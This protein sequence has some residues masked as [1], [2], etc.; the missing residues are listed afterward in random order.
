MNDC[1]CTRMCPICKARVGRHSKVS[2]WGIIIFFGLMVLILML[3]SCVRT[4]EQHNEIGKKKLA[5]LRKFYPDLFTK[6]VDTT[7]NRDSLVTETEWPDQAQIDSLLDE[8]CR[9]NSKPDTTKTGKD[10]IIYRDRTIAKYLKKEVFNPQKIYGVY[11]KITTK[12]AVIH[13]WYSPDGRRDWVVE[14]ETIRNTEECP[15]CPETEKGWRIQAGIVF[16]LLLIAFI[17]GLFFKTIVKLF[18]PLR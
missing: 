9:R 10:T 11:E 15:A 18:N 12:N 3:S 6:K 7:K 5:K 16:W 17:I 8:H 4:P 13:I 2:A 14:N 1:N